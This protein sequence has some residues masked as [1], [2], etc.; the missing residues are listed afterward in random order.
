MSHCASLASSAAASSDCDGAEMMRFSI[1]LS[2]SSSGLN[3]PDPRARTSATEAGG[4][5]S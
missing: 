1:L 4:V 3:T 5:M 2:R